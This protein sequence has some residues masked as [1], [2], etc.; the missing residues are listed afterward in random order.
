MTR[1]NVC[2]FVELRVF[3]VLWLF[4]LLFFFVFKVAT[5]KCIG[6]LFTDMKNHCGR[7]EKLACYFARNSSTLASNLFRQN[8]SIIT[9]QSKKKAYT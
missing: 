8:R 2:A 6:E 1:E 7:Q 9:R 3:C 5:V 4:F